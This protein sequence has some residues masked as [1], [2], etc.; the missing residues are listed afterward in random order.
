[1]TDQFYRTISERL[2][3]YM[4]R[5]SITTSQLA[6]RVDQQFNTIKGILEGRRFQAHHIVWLSNIIEVQIEEGDSGD[7]KYNRLE[8]FI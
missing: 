7:E 2:H 3:F 1:M 4:E 5:E 8:N 6:T